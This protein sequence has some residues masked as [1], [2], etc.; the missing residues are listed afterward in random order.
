MKV[1]LITGDKRFGPGHPR[2]ELQRSAVEDLKVLYWGRGSL[3]PSIE[4]SFD[5]VTAQDPFWRGLFAWR[6]A[7]RMGARL[8]VQVHTDLS[9]Y[10]GLRL[11]LAK[12]V[13][14]HAD[15]VRAVSEKIKKQVEAIGVHVPIQVLPIFVDLARFRGMARE[16]HAQKTILWVG[17][18]EEEKDPLQA[19]EILKRVRAAKVE[20]KLVMLG[21][22]SLD[23]AL[24]ARAKGFP[25]ELPGW[26]DPLPYLARA[27]VVLSTSR[28]E[29]WG[30]SM[31]EALAAG[32]AVVAPDVG[33]A[34]EAGAIVT[35]RSNLAETVA[36]ALRSG[37]RGE[38]RL[39]LP[40]AQ[41]WA[42][43]WKKTL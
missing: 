11:M 36:A 21:S 43:E 18:F 29:S 6:T 15:S 39:S 8:N 30:E 1:L 12:F 16:P 37:V 34:K 23:P 31:I 4:G 5:V 17:R 33:I 38:L 42:E 25:V 20:A 28:H 32:V 35:A 19:I 41:K 13:L 22:G 14:R 40:S 27:D 9:A 24:R 10:R 2:Y 26:S 7:R 3:L